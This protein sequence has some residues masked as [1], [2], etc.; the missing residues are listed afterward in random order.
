MKIDDILD[1]WKSY[2]LFIADSYSFYCDK[3]DS[4]PAPFVIL[5]PITVFYAI[6]H[7]APWIAFIIFCTVFLPL[8]WFF[9]LFVATTYCSPDAKSRK[10][11]DRP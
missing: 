5:L 11:R 3:T 7:F 4:W 1:K 2:T 10:Q 6:F 9:A 8:L